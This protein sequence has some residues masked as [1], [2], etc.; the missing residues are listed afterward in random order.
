MIR[1]GVHLKNPTARLIY[2]FL[3]SSCSKF[4][5]PTFARG[6]NHALE[7]IVI[8]WVSASDVKRLSDRDCTPVKGIRSHFM[9]CVTPTGKIGQRRLSCYCQFCQDEDWS[10][11]VTAVKAE[12]CINLSTVGPWELFK[13]QSTDKTSYS[14]RMKVRKARG[15]FWCWKASEDLKNTGVEPN[16]AK[17]HPD[18][19]FIA[20]D[21]SN[22]SQGH[23]FWIVRVTE[24]IETTDEYFEGVDGKKFRKG[25]KHLCVQLLTHTPPSSTNVF[26]MSDRIVYVHVRSVF[27]SGVKPTRH[28]GDQTIVLDTPVVNNIHDSLLEFMYGKD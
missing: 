5:N 27:L 7:S 25:D 19:T 12:G 18:E 28:V 4:S 17:L 20:L 11:E 9:F 8:L 1:F 14:E 22:D 10:N 24:P 15:T 26:T 3:I 16:P 6:L 21:E 23:T 13:M 2:E